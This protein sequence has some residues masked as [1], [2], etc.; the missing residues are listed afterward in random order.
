MNAMNLIGQIVKFRARNVKAADWE[1]GILESVDNQPRS[2]SFGFIR[3]KDKQ[4]HK[5]SLRDFVVE[6]R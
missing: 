1:V 5:I 2:E 3:M 4:L 6:K